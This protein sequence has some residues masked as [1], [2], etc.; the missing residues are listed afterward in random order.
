MSDKKWNER[1]VIFFLI[2]VIFL[3]LIIE[4]L[5]NL[6]PPTSRDALIHHLAIPKLWLLHGG[7]YEIPWADFSYYP[8]NIDLLYL[9]PLS[10]GNDIIPKFI[11]LFF[12]IG[13]GLLIYWY[14]GN[15]FGKPWGLLGFL[16]F[17]STPLIVHLST[18]AYV[19]LGMAFFTTA[20]ILAFIRWREE[21]YQSTKWLILSALCMGLAAGSKYN[22]LIAWFFLNAM[23]VF[24]HSKDTGKG[25]P[26]LKSGVMFFVV[27]LLIVSPWYIKNYILTGNPLYPLFDHFFKLLPQVGSE[28]SGLAVH[29]EHNWASNI[30]Q[31]RTAMFGETIW[32]T[33][34]IPIRMFFQ[35]K[36]ASPRYFDGVLNPIFIVMIPFAFLKNTVPRHM[37]FFLLFSLF[38]FLMA[39]FLTVVRVRYILPIIPILT[40]LTV[41]G[42]K[43]IVDRIPVHPDALRQAGLLGMSTAII[44]F[45]SM[46]V[47]YLKN[48]VH[49]IKPFQFIRGQETREAFLSR[50]EGSYPAMRYINENLPQ[51][52]RILLMF[53]GRRGYYLD[54]S[55]RHD[56]SFGMTKLSDMVK[57]SEER[58]TFLTYLRS[59]NCTH[60]LIRIDMF[61]KYLHDNYP[62]ETIARFLFCM[63]EYWNP[64]YGLNG[65]AVYKL[66]LGSGT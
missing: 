65:Y 39:Y 14:L 28:E 55:Y 4:V 10:F 15:R 44:I 63:K 8:M 34:L 1:V 37:I 25:L 20:S 2:A 31:R 43:N 51:E 49:I 64:V 57:A 24:Y 17:F 47:M 48:Y 35:G 13:T 19:D 11:H 16:I 61:N 23:I 42:M 26:A 38:F 33:L 50:H 27:T 41:T 9:V 53:L 60:V 40:I 54:R 59:L 12:G 3:F 5:L 18:T 45:L 52:S 29:V 66:S 58:I 46:N 36:D 30:F 56:P 62:K 7:M 21:G 22:A 6:T 32:E